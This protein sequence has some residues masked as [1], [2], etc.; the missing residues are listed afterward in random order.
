MCRGGPWPPRV[1]VALPVLNE[2]CSK[3]ASMVLNFEGDHIT[4]EDSDK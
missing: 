1:S 4:L 2:S 3:E